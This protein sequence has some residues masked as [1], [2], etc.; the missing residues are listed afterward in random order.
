MTLTVVLV[1]AVGTYVFRVVG[2]LAS[3]W[4]EIPERVHKILIWAAV[5]LLAGLVATQTFTQDGGFAG[6]SRVAGVVVGAI[7]AWRKASLV[8]VVIAAVATTALLRW[9]GV[10]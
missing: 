6:W 2:P 7:V 10:P 3:G 5:A 9:L 1:V 8:V 4:F